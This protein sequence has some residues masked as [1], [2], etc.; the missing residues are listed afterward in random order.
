MG[1]RLGK[2]LSLGERWV[3]PVTKVL[4]KEQIYK[5]MVLMGNA[6]HTL[7]PIGAQGFNLILQELLQLNECAKK[8][9]LDDPLLLKTYAQKISTYQEKIIKTSDQLM[10]ISDKPAWIYSAGFQLAD[11]SDAFKKEKIA[12]LSG[13]TSLVKKIERELYE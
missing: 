6:A 4:A 11:L 9:S 5:N 2:F 1:D 3:F 10:K 7:S 12:M 13:M 8:F